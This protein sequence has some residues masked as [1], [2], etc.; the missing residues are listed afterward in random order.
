M[1]DE[2]NEHRRMAHNKYACTHVHVHIHVHVHVHVH[3]HVH[4][5]VHTCTYQE[6]LWTLLYCLFLLIFDY[7]IKHIK[8]V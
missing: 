6:L 1:T 5:N 4:V 2:M 7:L 8:L 3:I